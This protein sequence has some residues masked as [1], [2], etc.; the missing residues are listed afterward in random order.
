MDP[1]PDDTDTPKDKQKFRP[2]NLSAVTKVFAVG[3]TLTASNNLASIESG[4]S[5]GVLARA[6]GRVRRLGNPSDV[7]YL[8][9]YYVE[10]TFDNRSV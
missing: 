9:E 3:L 7:V 4:H 5:L 10:G 8:Y 6:P 1:N 2:R